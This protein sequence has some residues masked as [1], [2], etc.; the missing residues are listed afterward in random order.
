MGAI[1]TILSQRNKIKAKLL[2]PKIGVSEFL[3]GQFFWGVL[4]DKIAA[5]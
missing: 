2:P 4:F 1:L 5:R 3:D